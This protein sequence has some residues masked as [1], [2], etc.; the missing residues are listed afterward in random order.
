[1]SDDNIIHMPTRSEVIAD[2]IKALE[3]KET[4]TRE[5]QVEIIV[6]KAIL[7]AEAKDLHLNAFTTWWD[8]QA[9]KTN[10][11]DRAALVAMG[12]SPDVLRDIMLN[13]TDRTSPQHIYREFGDNFRQ[14]TKI[15]QTPRGPGRPSGS[16]KPPTPN[17]PARPPTPQLDKARAAYDVLK[18]QGGPITRDA[19]AA[20]AGVGHTSASMAIA[21]KVA[22]AEPLTPAEMRASMRKRYESA[23]RKARAEIREQVKTE[24]YGEYDSYVRN[25]KTRCENAE[26]V[27]NN[28]KGIMPRELYRKIRAC[29]HP[30][31]N[32]FAHAAECLT[33]FTKLESVLVKPDAPV[34]FAGGLPN[35]VEEL[36]A[37][38]RTKKPF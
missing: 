31:H 27:L 9:F 10:H 25:F 26:R 17:N 13:K 5:D 23:L 8:A 16:K 30:D 36:M 19:L 24:V 11:D 29:L 12:S 32:T 15:Q 7:I 20:A 21:E 1:M 28:Y 22:G 3:T 2:K 34:V 6:A 38:R 14:V 18:A 33:E 35:T 37:R 4:K